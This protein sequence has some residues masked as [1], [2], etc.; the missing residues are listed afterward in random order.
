MTGRSNGIVHQPVTARPAGPDGFSFAAR[1]PEVASHHRPFELRQRTRSVCCFVDS[2]TARARRVRTCV[3]V[4]VTCAVVGVNT[5]SGRTIDGPALAD[6]PPATLQIP[7]AIT[8]TDETQD[9]AKALAIA[10]SPPGAS[11]SALADLARLG[12]IAVARASEVLTARFRAADLTFAF[13]LGPAD[14]VSDADAAAESECRRVILGERPGDGFVGE[15]QGVRVGHSGI[16]WILDPLDSTANFVRGIPIWSI[17][18]AAI[19]RIGPAIGIVGVPPHGEVF[20]A[21]RESAVHLNDRAL[22]QPPV[23][24]MEAAMIVIGWSPRTGGR[25]QSAIASQVI[26]RAGKV[27]SPGSPAL[28][29]AWTAAGRFDAAYYEMD[30]E[31]WDVAAGKLLCRRAGLTVMAEDP[32]TND[33]SPRI[34]ATPGHLSAALATLLAAE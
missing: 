9:P 14:V 8:W 4:P 17:S 22:H 27:R 28:G 32:I 11:S 30:F 10:D 33:A 5:M 21:T 26:G 19:D 29:L 18:L 15:E 7:L 2:R 34:L 31:E 1:K 16:T 25:R 12:L 23:R 6:R 20:W 24:P 13:K 3:A